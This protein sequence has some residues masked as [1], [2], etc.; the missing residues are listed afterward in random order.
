MF[1]FLSINTSV[2]LSC[3]IVA[4]ICLINDKSIAWR[5]MILFLLI[6]C[7]T[8]MAGLYVKKLYLADRV[9]VHPNL[10]LYNTLLIFQI[11]FTSFMFQHLLD[12]YNSRRIVITGLPIL[13]GL[14]IYEV[15]AHGIFSYNN[16]TNIALS[17]LL[18]L[19]SLVY[20]YHLLKDDEHAELI[21]LSAFWWAAGILFFHFGRTG[22]NLFYGKLASIMVTA[23]HNLT[24]Y[25]YI[26]LNILLYG[27]WAYSF[28]C[29]RWETR[30]S[31]N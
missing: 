15:V 18:V 28:I 19:Y 29:R 10:W 7:I 25:I 30:R 17:I 14:Y 6:T 11:G 23:K 13:I 12:K 8:E 20:Y 5:S 4:L 1:Q 3:F 9:H 21:S 26:I 2:E 31:V 24:Y 22:C 27:C 16:L